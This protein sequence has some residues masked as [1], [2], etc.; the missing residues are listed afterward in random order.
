MTAAASRT[1]G[2]RSPEN[3]LL[4]DMGLVNMDKDTSVILM[5]EVLPKRFVPTLP[6]DQARGEGR[7]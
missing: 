6:V 4:R 1:W 3:Q 7:V 2:L 5:P